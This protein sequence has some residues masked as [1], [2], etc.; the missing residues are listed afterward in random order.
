VF[1]LL[2]KMRL[3]SAVA[4]LQ[5]LLWL[6][7]SCISWQL[8]AASLTLESAWQ[9]AEQNSPD[10]KRI[11]SN[12]FAVEGE[13]QDARAPLYNNPV[14]NFEGRRRSIYEQGRSDPQRSEWG[15]GIAQT[16]E[17]A[18]QQGYRRQAAANR[19]D[20]L[21]QQIAETHRSVR[22]QVEEQFVNVLAIQ[23]RIETEQRTL[24]LIE[25]NTSL[26]RKRV[27]AGE[28]SKLDGN[29]AIVDAERARNQLSFQQEQL[30][31]ARADL[32]ASLQLPPPELPE[33]SGSIPPAPLNYTLDDLL[34]SVE[35][36]PAIKALSFRENSARSRLDLER[37]LRYPDLTV[38][39][40]NSREAGIVG[41]DNITT[42]GIS[43][44]I[45]LFRRNGAGIGRATSEL[46][47]VEVDRTVVTRD[48]KALIQSAW[49]RRQNLQERFDRLNREVYPKLEE[50]LRLS[51]LGFQN[52]EIGLPQ[53]LI[54][55]RQTI[56]AQ[57]DVVEAERDLRLT[58]I[59]LEYA[60]GWPVTFPTVNK[61]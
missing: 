26:S 19:R 51:M 7:L 39:L 36:R 23:R 59:E 21:E 34:R 46:T 3:P 16:F 38:S 56:D 1:H 54:V 9:I 52:G 55:Q 53:L 45:P 29:L 32:A 61:E 10:L 11:T 17:V 60:A 24:E 57:R 47:Q 25:R 58:Q 41:D 18:G 49:L 40:N 31:R 50:N 12:R 20:E 22:A 42:V 8:N 37:S 13:L 30:T 5:T 33:V 48:S 15:G 2:S 35:S 4:H 43:L 28:D 6:G 14:V 44:P 27:S